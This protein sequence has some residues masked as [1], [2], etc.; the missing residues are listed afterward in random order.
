MLWVKSTLS[1]RCFR[2]YPDTVEIQLERL[3]DEQKAKADD[4]TPYRGVVYIL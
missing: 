1:I 3:T 2:G 4:E